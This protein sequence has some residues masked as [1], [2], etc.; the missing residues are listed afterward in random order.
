MSLN[1]LRNFGETKK[2]RHFI[3][4]LHR[5]LMANSVQ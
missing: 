4:D 1:F 3:D 5:T 2:C